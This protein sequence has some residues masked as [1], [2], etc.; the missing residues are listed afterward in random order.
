MENKKFTWADLKKVVNELPEDMLWRDVRWWGEERGGT[1]K[2]VSLL[3]EVYVQNDEGFEPMSAHEGSED[4]YY[5]G[6]ELPAG[7]PILTVD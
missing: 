4:S 3:D 7:Y 2:S 1:V 6:S 5:E